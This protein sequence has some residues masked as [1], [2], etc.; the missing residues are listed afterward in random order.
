[1]REASVTVPSNDE[2][3]SALITKHGD[4]ALY[5]SDINLVLTEDPVTSKFI[6]EW[7]P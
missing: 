3:L 2:T 5:H 7:H 1:M 6:L 4:R